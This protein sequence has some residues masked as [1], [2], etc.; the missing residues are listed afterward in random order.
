MGNAPRRCITPLLPFRTSGLEPWL[1]EDH[2]PLQH[3]GWIGKGLDPDVL[4]VYTMY[5][6]DCTLRGHHGTTRKVLSHESRQWLLQE[7]WKW[8]KETEDR[9]TRHPPNEYTRFSWYFRPW[10]HR[11]GVGLNQLAATDNW[12]DCH[13]PL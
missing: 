6:D 13:T 7:G 10:H 2:L 8:F 3:A 9:R 11:F 4:C 12:L 1:S 5:Y